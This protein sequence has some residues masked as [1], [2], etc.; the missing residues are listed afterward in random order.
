MSFYAVSRGH[1]LT[2]SVGRFDGLE[3]DLRNLNRIAVNSDNV[4]AHFQGGVYSQE[5]IRS[6]WDQGFVTGESYDQSLGKH[7]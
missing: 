3:I 5:V 2:T 7:I 1:A 6:L 4:T